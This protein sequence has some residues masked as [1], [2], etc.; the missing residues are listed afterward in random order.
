[1]IQ[2]Y[3]DQVKAL[4]N[5]Y[6]VTHFVLEAKVSSEMRPGEQGYLTGSITFVDSSVL[7]FREY[8]DR[9]EGVVEKLMYTYHYQNAD[10][11]LVFRYDNA[12]HRPPLGSLEHKHTPGKV[13]EVPAP[14][15]EDV[16]VEIV[17]AQG[18]V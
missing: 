18:L 5:Q 10:H 4:V 13:V 12:R 15:L 11:Q 7:H 1:M 2:A 14:T 8:F 6:A 17:V 16:L 3:F 9:I